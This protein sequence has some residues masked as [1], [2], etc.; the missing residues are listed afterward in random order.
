M[1]LAADTLEDEIEPFLLRCG[2]L[3]R[4]PR[5]R[6]ATAATFTHLKLPPPEN[7]NGS[8]QGRLF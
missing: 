7:E 4:T 5:G 6:M 8:G 3:Q 2:L 1:N